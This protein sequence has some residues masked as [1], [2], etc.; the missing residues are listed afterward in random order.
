MP[1]TST[2]DVTAGSGTHVATYDIT[3][4]AATKKIQRVGLN[5]SAGAEINFLPNAASNG[6]TES[7][8]VALATSNTSTSLKASAGNI[9]E[10]DVFNTAAYT[11]FLKFY[12]KA[13]APTVGTDTPI[14]TI[15]IA[16]GTG[17]SNS[18]A[19]GGSNVVLI[20]ERA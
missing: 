13:S 4:D 11:V 14:W 15:P 3:E 5:T 6:M 16:A 9:Y 12:N 8:V 20:A 1:T 7:R 10:I 17:Y 18:F 2:V 19:F